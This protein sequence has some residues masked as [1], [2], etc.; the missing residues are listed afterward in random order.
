[1]CLG[2]KLTRELDIKS[3]KTV[4]SFRPHRS[5]AQPVNIN[6]VTDQG[7]ILESGFRPGLEAASTIMKMTNKMQYI[8]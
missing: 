5:S 4:A 1:M 8:D 6:R 7:S 2:L 3:C